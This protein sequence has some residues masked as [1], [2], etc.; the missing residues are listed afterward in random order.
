M[1]YEEA[2]FLTLYAKLSRIRGFNTKEYCSLLRGKHSTLT[3]AEAHDRL[4]ELEAID[5]LAKEQAALY[6]ADAPRLF[7]ELFSE[8]TDILER[9]IE[10]WHLV[11]SDKVAE[12]EWCIRPNVGNYAAS[13]QYGRIEVKVG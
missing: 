1:T 6:M 4:D 13:K 7:M 10:D 12:L 8:G 5:A 3:G 11:P 9:F 2:T